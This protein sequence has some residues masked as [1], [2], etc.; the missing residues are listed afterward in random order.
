MRKRTPILIIITVAFV[1]L[2][3]MMLERR[4]ELRL[5][6]L[7][8]KILKYRPL[9]KKHAAKQRLDWLLLSALI[10]QESGFNE[11]AVSSIGAQGLMQLMP[12]TAEELGVRD[13]LDAEQN[14]EGATRYLRK[15]YDAFADSSHEDRLQLALA[16]YNGG[17]GHLR[18]AQ[19]VVIHQGAEPGVWA[20]IRRALPRLTE[21]DARLHK[22]VWK[23]E[24]KPP[25]GYFHGFRETLAYVEMVTAYYEQLCFY[26]ELLF[27]SNSG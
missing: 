23:A 11:R 7:T 1:V 26:R 5:L 6:I 25:H 15:L 20:I 21:R 8:P 4:Q 27:F 14:I 12:A 2:S 19:T 16:S 22:N 3:Y 9:L 13:A 24:G 17:I 10:I 18:D